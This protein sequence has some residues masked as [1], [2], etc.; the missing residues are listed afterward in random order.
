[1]TIC[2]HVAYK[3]PIP[4]PM[5]QPINPQQMPTETVEG[6]VNSNRNLIYNAQLEG[7]RYS[8]Q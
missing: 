4:R 3:P 1:M 5:T 2:F 8:L 6:G 7:N